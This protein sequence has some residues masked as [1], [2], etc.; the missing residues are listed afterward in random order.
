M[1]HE[2]SDAQNVCVGVGAAFI[3]AILL[4]PTYYF[5]VVWSCPIFLSFFIDKYLLYLCLPDCIG[6]T[7]EHKICH[8]Q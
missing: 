1:S 7:Q 8:S 3:E 2:L 4:Q 6:K 5:T